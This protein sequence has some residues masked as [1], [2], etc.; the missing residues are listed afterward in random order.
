MLREIETLLKLITRLQNAPRRLSAKHEHA[1]LAYN[2][3]IVTLQKIEDRLTQ[4]CNFLRECDGTDKSRDDKYTEN[5]S[6]MLTAIL[7]IF[8]DRWGR[9]KDT[10]NVYFEI[11]DV[12]TLEL[13]EFYQHVARLIKEVIEEEC[14]LKTIYC[15]GR[16]ELAEQ[17]RE[18]SE[19]SSILVTYLIC[20]KRQDAPPMPYY[21]VSRN[22][23][24]EVLI[25][26]N[27][28]HPNFNGE[29]AWTEVDTLYGLTKAQIGLIDQ[30]KEANDE[31]ILRSTEKVVDF[32]EL[33]IK[34]C[35]YQIMFS[36]LE[37]KDV[38][39]VTR[40]ESVIFE[41]CGTEWF[42][43][44]RNV[45]EKYQRRKIEEINDIQLEEN[46]DI[47]PE[48]NIHIQLLNKLS[49]TDCST[50]KF[51]TGSN[52][53]ALKQMATSFGSSTHKIRI[54]DCQTKEEQ[55]EAIISAQKTGIFNNY[56]GLYVSHKNSIITFYKGRF[57]TLFIAKKQQKRGLFS[58]FDRPKIK[59]ISDF[60][61]YKLERWIAKIDEYKHA[62]N[63]LNLE[64]FIA[65]T[66]LQAEVTLDQKVG[67]WAARCA[68]V[69]KSNNILLIYNSANNRAQKGWH[70][71][72][73]VVTIIDGEATEKIEKKHISHPKVYGLEGHTCETLHKEDPENSDKTVIKKDAAL[74]IYNKIVARHSFKQNKESTESHID[75]L[76]QSVSD[77]IKENRHQSFQ[78]W[79]QILIPTIAM[80][81]LELLE[82]DINLWEYMLSEDHQHIFHIDTS[83]LN[84]VKEGYLSAINPLIRMN[85]TESMRLE[86]YGLRSIKP[87]IA[88]AKKK[89]DWETDKRSETYYGHVERFAEGL[90]SGSK[91]GT[92][93]DFKGSEHSSG[94]GGDLARI[95]FQKFLAWVEQNDKGNYRKLMALHVYVWH[96]YNGQR[97][98]D[99]YKLGKIWR[100]V[101]KDREK[102]RQK[103][104]KWRI[105]STF[106]FG[107][108]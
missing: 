11:Y 53:D 89:H 10:N 46:N 51:N 103:K 2:E 81:D 17:R 64:Q 34:R 100:I 13:N 47:Q 77:Y 95:K 27:Q 101:S 62:S 26:R 102:K 90:L 94:L 91:S 5:L 83:V 48:E 37:K 54:V 4:F 35:F 21:I 105:S 22:L 28:T 40:A 93:K 76:W 78:H 38:R 7:K 98:R 32:F 86:S 99:H 60:A 71:A 12:F 57:P 87:L 18:C 16:E 108:T 19:N 107:S 31:R 84:V 9:I 65:I 14:K 67:M 80:T 56:H 41:K 42:I 6:E 58:I 43:H 106:L 96:T 3:T 79:L 97:Y 30:D 20:L 59:V 70:L 82:P 50:I 52:R 55:N 74:P 36:P 15:E 24:N 104:T 25:E 61:W 49:P 92:S 8:T 1:Y 66:K 88:I 68:I 73:R 75:T 39:A 63:D 44:F 33:K 72:T 45:Q 69:S 29:R 23:Q 85:Y